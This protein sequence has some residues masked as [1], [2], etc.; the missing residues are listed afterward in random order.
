[1][2]GHEEWIDEESPL[3]I[4]EQANSH[5]DELYAWV[6]SQTVDEIRDLATAFRIPNAPVGNGANVDIARPIRRA[7]RRSSPIRAT[8][9]RSPGRRTACTPARLRAP[10][11]A[12][13]LGE[14][15]DHYR[16]NGHLGRES[17]ASSDREC[18]VSRGIAVRGAAGARHDD[19]SG[20][21]RPARTCWRMLGAEVIHVESTR[22]ARRHPAD[23]G[24]PDHRGP[25]VGAVT[26]L[27]GPEHQQEEA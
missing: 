23:R 19:A 18:D 2:T 3:S 17:G 11:P 21:G 14:H 12:P 16:R 8:G 25:V 4:T 22:T 26:D 6:A 7:R 13:R 1:M 20:P 15:T 10:Q 9:S 24:H 5:A 27:L